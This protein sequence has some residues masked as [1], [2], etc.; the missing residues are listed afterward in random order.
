[1]TDPTDSLQAAEQHWIETQQSLL[2]EWRNYTDKQRESLVKRHYDLGCLLDELAEAWSDFSD[3]LV[4]AARARI[5]RQDAAVREHVCCVQVAAEDGGWTWWV[6]PEADGQITQDG[7]VHFTTGGEARLLVRAF[8]TADVGEIRNVPRGHPLLE[9]MTE[10]TLG[11]QGQPFAT[12]E[13]FAI[14]KQES[15]V[16][17]LHALDSLRPNLRTCPVTDCRW[18]DWRSDASEVEQSYATHRRTAHPT[19]ASA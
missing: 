16:G 11:N 4:T 6:L 12:E 13:D 17:G 8:R 3:A 5:D 10:F 7:M 19:E 2:R 18:Q 15:G 1:M 9:T 14:S